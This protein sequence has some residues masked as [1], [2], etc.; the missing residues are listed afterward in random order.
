MMY[1][2]GSC[3]E[4]GCWCLSLHMAPPTDL[5]IWVNF[6]FY[7]TLGCMSWEEV[8]QSSIFLLHLSIM[9]LLPK[10]R[11]IIANLPCWS[12]KLSW[13]YRWCSS[14]I[15]AYSQKA[16]HMLSYIRAWLPYSGEDKLYPSFLKYSQC[17]VMHILLLVVNFKCKFNQ[18]KGF[19]DSWWNII[20]RFVCEGISRGD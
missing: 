5:W 14:E 11:L 19:P 10:R 6:F 20:S 17:S 15:H 18:A 16:F 2:I 9:L 1:H 4:T 12:V 13:R 8:R 3:A 7:R